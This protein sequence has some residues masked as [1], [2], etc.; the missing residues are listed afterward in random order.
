[1]LTVHAAAHPEITPGKDAG[2][3]Q[4]LERLRHNVAVTLSSAVI[5]STV[6]GWTTSPNTAIFI[7]ITAVI[8]GLPH[9]AL[10]VVV[11]PSM[12]PRS[13]FYGS[14][15]T[16]VATVSVAWLIAPLLSLSLFLIASWFHFARGDAEHHRQLGSTGSLV[17]MS[18]A[19]CAIGLPLALHSDTVTPLLSDL[20]LGTA[21]LSSQQVAALGA[22]IVYPS[23]AAGVVAAVAAI[24]THRFH[25]VV[26]L[27]V[28]ALLA[29]TVHPLIS[30]ALYFALWHSPRHLIAQDID[31]SAVKPTL[32][33]TFA[34]LL[35]AAL[36]VKLAEPTIQTVT[37]VIFIGLAALTGPHLVVTELLRHR[38]QQVRRSPRLALPGQQATQAVAA[39]PS[40]SRL[41][42]MPQRF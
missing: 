1:M 42:N 30:F 15:L 2:R 10:D 25:A 7:V 31:A 17:G 27:L 6:V 24:Q 28:I 37:Q 18:T 33:A 19:G 29:G 34:T 26:E 12:A 9:G 16:F 20:L 40:G 39:S 36:I 11:G 13:I 22:F 3:R 21:T 8:A 41:R 38:T 32:V 5:A 35:A 14:Y 4:R 23:A